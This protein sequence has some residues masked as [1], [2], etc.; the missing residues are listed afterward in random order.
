MLQV[1][2]H[3]TFGLAHGT[4]VPP[5]PGSRTVTSSASYSSGSICTVLITALIFI[6]LGLG[7]V[8][9]DR[10]MFAGAVDNRSMQGAVSRDTR[11]S[12]HRAE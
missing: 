1:R 3:F 4:Q 9:S 12:G 11:G 7:L 2:T 10:G 6:E 5:I 8:E